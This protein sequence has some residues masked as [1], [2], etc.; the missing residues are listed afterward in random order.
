MPRPTTLPSEGARAAETSA[1]M[2]DRLEE[3]LHEFEKELYVMATAVSGWPVGR[4]GCSEAEALEWHLN[5]TAQRLQGARDACGA[6]RRW[7]TRLLARQLP[8]T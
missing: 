1:E 4:A 7:S 8:A 5:D 3:S 6:C 2:L